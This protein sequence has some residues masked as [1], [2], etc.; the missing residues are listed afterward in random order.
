MA[1]FGGRTVR[2]LV[3]RTM[4]LSRSAA[5]QLSSVSTSSGSQPWRLSGASR[6][7]L[8]PLVA[9][10]IAVTVGVWSTREKELSPTRLDSSL[11][12]APMDGIANDKEEPETTDVINWSGTHKITIDNDKL[13]EPESVEEVEAFV[14]ECQRRGQAIRPIGSSLSPNGI[15]LN[16]A[17]MIQMANIDRVLEIDTENKTI[18]VEAGITVQRVVEAL[19]PHGLTLPN[20]ASI[21]EQQ[22]GGFI[23]VGAHGTGKA[24]APVDHYVTRLKLVTPGL[25]TI[26]LSKEENGTLFEVAKVAV[27]C[28]GVV[29][30]VT[31]QCIPAHNLLEHTFVL[32]RQE[33]KEQLD[34]LLKNHKHMRYMW[35]PYTDTVVCVT[36]DPEHLVPKTVPRNKLSMGSQEEK[37]QPLTDLYE[38]LCKEYKTPFSAEDMS[39]M[40]FGELRDALLAFA[41][42]DI[43][44]IKRCNKAEAEFWSMSEG[45]QTKPSDQLLQFDCGGQVGPI[46]IYLLTL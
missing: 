45:Y 32:K 26:V 27:G 12:D 1:P 13:W 14:E 35:I 5:S 7:W 33:A 28:L 37:M 29:V 9:S 8:T 46:I 15:A 30:E 41:P 38:Q 6:Q 20:L 36:N 17:G 2:P 16:A 10:A 4:N 43:E 42:L 34:D 31:M 25:G 40:G 3:K 19:R 22:I 18:T 39:G 11:V 44:H 21:A 24:V 23:Q